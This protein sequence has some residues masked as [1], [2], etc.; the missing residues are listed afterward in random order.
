M[1]TLIGPGASRGQSPAPTPAEAAPDL[2]VLCDFSRLAQVDLSGADLDL[3]PGDPRPRSDIR[4]V[5][6]MSGGVDSSVVAALLKYAGYD[7]VGVTLQLYDFGAALKK[8]GACCAGQDIHDARRVAEALNI[9]HYVLDYESRFRQQ[10]M[11]DF[12]DTYLKGSTPIPCIRCNQTVKFSDLLATAKDLGAD[13]MA[14]GHYIRRT[15]GHNGHAELSRAAD[16]D[17]DQS[18]FLFATT[19]QQLDFLRFPLGGMKKPDVRRAASALGLQVAAKPDSQDIC[20]VPA[21]KYSDIV[22]K[23]RP[24]A[25]EPGDIVH[26]DGRIMGRHEGVIRYT[27]GQRRGLGVATG[28]PLFVVKLDAPNKRVIVGPREALATAAL[29]IGESNWLGEGSLA[30]ACA[31]HAP[32]LA[33]VRSTRA[34]VAGRMTLIDGQPGFTFDTPEE[35]VAPGQ[36]CVLYAAPDG[37]TVLGGGFITATVSAAQE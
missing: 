17:R 11:E 29:T 20:F 37:R 5:A 13:A 18:Y 23:L 22:E 8:Q 34:P 35:G 25:S 36:A 3:F 9:P 32:A 30:D 6:A 16:P 4:V 28:E 27:I 21:G 31:N 33:R 7:V 15:A 14:T 1:T 26:M 10:V 19:R 12:A 2:G 24:G